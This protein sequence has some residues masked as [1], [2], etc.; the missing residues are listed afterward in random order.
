[1]ALGHDRVLADRVGEFLEN[2]GADGLGI[3]SARCW[4][5]HLSILSVPCCKGAAYR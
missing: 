4:L 2:L 5:D 1:M 3:G